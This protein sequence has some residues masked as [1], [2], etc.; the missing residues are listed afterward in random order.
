[1]ALP[2]LPASFDR[3]TVVAWFRRPLLRGGTEQMCK[4][5]CACG[6]RFDCIWQSLRTGNTRS[7]GCLRSDSSSKNGPLRAR[8]GHA[9]GGRRTPEYRVWVGMHTRCYNDKTA[10][11]LRYGGRGICV[12][13][14]WHV[15]ENFLSDMGPRPSG[16][17]LDRIDNDGNYEP[18]NCR[19]A[20]PVEQCRNRSDN[21]FFEHDGHRATLVE[22]SER[23]GF[24]TEC[25]WQRIR[26][27]WS[28]KD[29]LTKP[30]RVAR[31]PGPRRKA[32]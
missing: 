23:T 10:L 28:L 24:T 31:G 12:C 15:F 4:C 2:E 19:W 17:S 21:V 27:G 16:L 8:H 3:V 30:L 6:T 32:A 25:I 22:W 5:E 18:V 1:M 14:R 26:R 11:Y 20:T 7:C 13:E 29:A 9:R